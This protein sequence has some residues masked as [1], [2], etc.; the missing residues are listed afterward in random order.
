MWE[1]RPIFLSPWDF[2]LDSCGLLFC[3]ALSDE[4]MG[5]WFTVAAGPRQRSPRGEAWSVF[6]Q[7]QSIVSQYVQKV[8]PQSTS[9]AAYKDEDQDVCRIVLVLNLWSDLYG[10]ICWM[11]TQQGAQGEGVI[12]T[13]FRHPLRLAMGSPPQMKSI[14][15]RKW[16][17]GAGVTGGM[18]WYSGHCRA[19][20][21]CALLLNYSQLRANAVTCARLVWLRSTESARDTH[22]KWTQAGGAYRTVASEAWWKIGMTSQFSGEPLY[23]CISEEPS[24]SHSEE[25]FW[26]IS[27][28]VLF[29]L[30]AQMSCQKDWNRQRPT[31]SKPVTTPNSRLVR[32]FT[33]YRL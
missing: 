7:Y 21:H 8:R 14:L 25:T 30:Y 33:V 22:F 10:G 19:T 1:S 18:S 9:I 13:P 29:I 23:T 32:G 31:G 5:L 17:C 12:F 20:N 28:S 4:R 24:S 6:C 2:L 15:W 27:I 16:C 3:S 11:L 26:H